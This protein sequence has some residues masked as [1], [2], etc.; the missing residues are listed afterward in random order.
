MSE[1]T[2]EIEHITKKFGGFVA[3]NNINL[4]LN[5]GEVLAL[6]GENGAG[7]STLMS[8]LSGIH[9]PTSGIIKVHGQVVEITN[10]RVS[11]DLGIG[12]V[13][14]HFMQVPVFTVLENI[15]LGDE[16]TNRRNVE[17]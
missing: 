5:R 10:P 11:K 15:I 13:Y 1:K 17:K 3:N 7:K 9:R 16:P 6:L 14:Q 8:M 4:H 12:M 2:I